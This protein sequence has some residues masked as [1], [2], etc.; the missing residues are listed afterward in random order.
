MIPA[1]VSKLIDDVYGYFCG[2]E[3]RV[4]VT[5][6]AGSSIIAPVE[7]NAN[8]DAVAITF[9]LEYDPTALTNPRVVLGDAFGPDAVLTFNDT[10][11]GEIG[12][13]VDS[14]SQMTASKN[15]KT[16]VFVTFDMV[17]ETAQPSVSITGSVAPL[18]VSDPFGNPLAA[19]WY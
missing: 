2:S 4:G 3:I 6:P 10:K 19:R 7:I 5:R 17:G 15:S 1:S 8:G 11:E 16:V 14:A 13:L 9:T 12:I 18:S